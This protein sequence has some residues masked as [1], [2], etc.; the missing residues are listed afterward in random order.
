MDFAAAW[1]ALAPGD[2]VAVSDGRPSPSANP[3]SMA[4]RI[5]RSHNFAGVL[6]EKIDGP[7]RALRFDLAADG[8]GNVIGFSVVEG[9]GHLFTEES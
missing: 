5:W 7:P 3:A 8:A 9:F 6:V 2:Q 4:A 1:D